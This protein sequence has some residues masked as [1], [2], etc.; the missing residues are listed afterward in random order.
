MVEFYSGLS[1]GWVRA[2]RKPNDRSDPKE[3][4]P[5][6]SFCLSLNSGINELCGC[7]VLV[8]GVRKAAAVLADYP[9]EFRPCFSI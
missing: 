2:L 4:R 6:R 7:F 9:M 3:G 5:R 8:S 1:R